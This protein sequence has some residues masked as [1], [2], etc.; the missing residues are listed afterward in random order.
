MKQRI[1]KVMNESELELY[2]DIHG[3]QNVSRVCFHGLR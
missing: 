2:Q 1:T 3:R